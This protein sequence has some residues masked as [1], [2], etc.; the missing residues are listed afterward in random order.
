VQKPSSSGNIIAK[1]SGFKNLT[2][3]LIGIGGFFIFLSMVYGNQPVINPLD[4][5][6]SFNPLNISPNSESPIITP[7]ISPVNPPDSPKPIKLK[8]P[9]S[10]KITDDLSSGGDSSG[11]YLHNP[12]NVK[13]TIEYDP[14]YREYD[15]NETIGNMFYRN[16]DYMTFDEFNDYMEQQQLRNYWKQKTADETKTKPGAWNPKLYINN[17]IFDRI[18]GGNTIDIKPQG[19]AELIFAYNRSHNDNPALPLTQRT[20][21]TFDFNE[22]IQMN[23]TAQI[24]DK[25]KMGVNY[26]TEATF[27]FENKMKLEYT[28]KEDEIIKKIEAGNITLPLNNSL[29]TGSQTL[30]GLKTQLQFGALTVTA[31]FAQQKG[32]SNTINVQGGAQT[33]NYSIKGDQYEANKHFFLAQF[34]HDNY[35]IALANTPIISSSINITQIEVWVTNRT[36]AVTNTRNIVAFQDL[37][38]QHPFDSTYIH[39]GSSVYPDNKLSNDLYLRITT[40][41]ILDSIRNVNKS[42]SILATNIPSMSGDV[43]Y[44]QVQNARKLLPT[45]YTFNRQL[46]YISLNQA[47]N[48]GDVLGVAFE[49]QVIGQTGTFKVGELTSDGISTPNALI[50]KLLQS[51]NPN[52]KVPTWKL[53]MKNIYSLGAYQV[54][55]TNFLLNVMYLNDGTGTKI[56]FIPAGANLNGKPLLQV[57]NLDKLDQNNDPQ[58]DGIFDFIDGVTINSSN[59][60]IIFPQAE[61][62]GNFLANK[63]LPSEQ[64]LANKYV[65][66]AL[67]DS[68]KTAAQQ[69]PQFDKFYIEGSYQSSNNSEISL[70][71]LNIPQGSVSVT[72]GGVKLVENQDY[73]VDYT[74]GRL[75]I[76]N[77]GILASGIPIQINVESNSMFNIQAKTMWGARLDYKVSNDFLLGGTLL[78]LGEQPLTQKVNV[79]DIPV[80]NTI[81]GFDWTY[82]TDSRLITKLVDDLPLIHT[83]EPSSVTFTGEFAKL[84]PG[85]SN[86]IGQAGNAYIDDFEGSST[87]LDISNV[88]TWYIA[89]TPQGQPN[90]FP[91][92]SLSN[93]LAYGYNRAK[94]C[95]YNIDPLFVNNNSLTPTY[96][97]NN[98]AF[99]SSHFVRPV[100][101]TEIFPNETPANGL[102]TTLLV[103]NVGYYPKEKGPYNY[104]VSNNSYAKG[105]DTTGGLTYPTTRWGGIMRAMQTTDFEASNIDFLE[106]W[107]MDPY[108]YNEASS[109]VGDLYFNLGD[110]SEDI[111][112]DGFMSYENGLP[113]DGSATNMDTVSSVWGWV[114][115]VQEVIN[116]FSNDPNARAN[117]DVGLDGLIDA[118]E[119]AHFQPYLNQIATIFGTGS[120]AY[121]KA[122]S[123]PSNDDYTYYMN[124]AYDNAQLT[125]LD[126]YKAYNGLEGNSVISS[127]STP[128]S[129]TNYP[130]AEDINKDFTM[131]SYENYYQYHVYLRPNMQVGQNN[132][133]S[134]VPAKVTLA[135]GTTSTVNWYQFKVPI[136]TPDLTV[137]SIE[138]FNSIRFMRMFMRGFSDSIIL[139]FGFLRL[140][141]DDWRKYTFSLETPGEIKPNNHNGT[142]FNVGVV[143]LNE[144]GTRTPINYVLP[145]GIQQQVNIATTNLQKLNEQSLDLQ[146]CGLQ[147]GDARA[148]Y[149]NL[150][151]DSRNFAKIQM[152]VH[153]EALEG[154]P[155]HNGDLRCFIRFGTDFTDNYYEYEM[156]ITFDLNNSSNPN[157]VWPIANNMIINI[158]ELQTAKQN[159]NSSGAPVTNLYTIADPLNPNNN[160]YVMGNPT[161][162]AVKVVMIGVRNPKYDRV[163]NPH[164]DA[165]PKCAEVWVDELRLT[166]FIEDGGWAANTRVITKLAD[167]GTVTLAASKKTFGFGSIDQTVDQLSKDDI[168]TFDASSSLELGKFLPP[169]SGIKVP[170]YV[171]Y[172]HITDIPKYDPNDPDILLQ[173]SI[174]EA[175]VKNPRVGDSLKQVSYDLTTRKSLNFTNVRKVKVGKSK[176]HIYDIENWSLTYAYSYMLHTNYII[177]HDFFEDH[178]G[179]IAYNFTNNP[180]NITPFAKMSALNHKYYKLLKDFNFYLMPTNIAFR[181]DVDRQYEETQL[182]N[183][184]GSDF[185]LPTTYNKNFLMNRTYDLK[186]DLTKSLKFDFNAVNNGR[187]DEPQGALDTREKIDTVKT[188]FWDLGRTVHYHHAANLS[189]AV[190]LS[191]IPILDWI[192]LNAKYGGVYDWMAGP[193]PIP[194]VDPTTGLPGAPIN[195]ANTIQNSNT[196]QL[197]AQFNMTNL[198]NKVPFLKKINTPP[199]PPP[200]PEKAVPKPKNDT[201]KVKK[202]IIKKP[203]EKPVPEVVRV[204]GKL[205]MSLKTV[206]GTYT[207]TNGTGLPGYL[208]NSY[209][210]GND[211]ARGA[212]GIPFVFGQQGSSINDPEDIRYRAYHNGWITTDTNQLNPT[213]QNH[214]QNYTIRGTFEPIKNMRI[215]VNFMRNYSENNSVYFH[216][217]A[218]ALQITNPT[219]SGTFSISY[220]SIGTAFVKDN[221]D[222]SNQT[223]ENFQNYRFQIASR[224]ASSNPY[225]RTHNGL[226]SANFPAGYGPSSQNVLLPAFL[227]AYGAQN[228]ATVNIDNP[229]LKIPLPNW[230]F[231]YDGLGK[232]PALSQIFTSINLTHGY[233]S[234]FNINSYTTDI[235]YDQLANFAYQ[236]NSIG[237]YYPKYDISQATII[238][239]FSPL[240]GIDATLK[241]SLL[242]KLE[243]RASRTIS[244]SFANTQITEVKSN[245]VVFGTGYKFKKVK[246]PINL[247]GKTNPKSDLIVKLDVSVREDRTIIHQIDPESNLPVAGV[248]VVSVKTSADYALNQ[249][250]TLRFFIT[251][252]INTPYVS[253][254]FPTSNLN[255][256]F[257]IRFTLNP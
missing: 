64:I 167:L 171:G 226:D 27:D 69:L 131:S 218:G 174:N 29:I 80:S 68:T 182:R 206:S 213:T 147:D 209:I 156:P 236:K 117:Q 119:R 183:T 249:R 231:T 62:F 42:N 102:P 58:P 139:R 16:P 256:G 40:S 230:R 178:K 154:Q 3:I 185:T 208:P 241:S 107:L 200:K 246:F 78:H 201:S 105:I 227:A 222:Y 211:L 137:G 132:I 1:K 121:Q 14:E 81:Y 195:V 73:T 87:P 194:T 101:E 84:I 103:M 37:A 77:S 143:N 163:I 224:L 149:K 47:L 94:F 138:D 95:W 196:K 100:L 133:T 114:P 74:L 157:D 63:F 127:G 54:S 173:N 79:A 50:V 36:G 41:S 25:M 57:L 9:F 250:V 180:K 65:Y 219:T 110:I 191:K 85:H 112:K 150:S 90:L 48:S 10:D 255:G 115:A 51:T 108:V 35:D 33:T 4:E 52:P 204:I 212:P 190:P 151:F 11:M 86:S 248:T 96:I 144:N 53:M 8:Y 228:P 61:P 46:G 26:N 71:A 162:S 187:I 243:Y 205:L 220:I 5:P 120:G 235:N 92:A 129:E 148:A 166:D 118:Q 145:P 116:A 247:G 257:S 251:D 153:G 134:I 155:I 176:A 30:F 66:H 124:S 142:L 140:I 83:K 192:T 141:R 23:V 223:F 214:I 70:N 199:P 237:D 128:T 197:N 111:L 20:V 104:V 21:S 49:Y 238:E 240:L 18:F 38:E 179:A 6:I 89:S 12:S 44:D 15:I 22:K 2:A 193:L 99:Q 161:L 32:Q 198:Y 126:R 88:G 203:V 19:S 152:F 242:L 109:N 31:L 186:F 177:D 93:N 172:S 113:G 28:G 252:V 188:N 43:D 239:T 165:L 254:T 56:N 55:K 67:Y 253:T 146:V 210:L 221:A 72:A 123:D 82:K 17:A 159:R 170:M 136:R 125:I 135:N 106:F 97:A 216:D 234:T 91:E 164:D 202:P 175:D 76:I 245:E 215:E 60:R 184:A 181:T 130:D 160:I 13:T 217:S 244:L 169:K 24:G 225:F 98:T 122:S 168:T 158:Q 7:P 233:Q 34:F 45:E 39:A 229:F 75:K 207:E 232:L 189:W 59:G